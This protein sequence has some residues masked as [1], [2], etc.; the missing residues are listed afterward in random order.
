MSAT[1]SECLPLR[2]LLVLPVLVL[3]LAIC[4]PAWLHAAEADDP[5]SAEGTKGKGG[6]LGEFPP[7]PADWPG[8]DQ[9]PYP[10]SWWKD[11]DG[12]D[13][14]T[15][16]CHEGLVDKDGKLNGRMFGEACIDDNKV[17]I[18]SNPE[19]D[20]PHSHEN[21]IGHPYHYDC[22]KWCVCQG[23]AKG[24]C[25]PEHAPPCSESAK[26]SCSD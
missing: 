14:G 23:H 10:V 5:P 24:V 17:L 20:K 19:K 2:R 16:G 12:V 6:Q 11:S 8:R 22:Q 4:I 18:E 26:C 13:P 15:A 21:D 7:Q 3:V 1:R 9:P 25:V